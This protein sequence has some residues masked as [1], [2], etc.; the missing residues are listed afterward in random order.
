M[1]HVGENWHIPHLLISPYYNHTLALPLIHN[2]YKE[3]YHRK[4]ILYMLSKSQMHKLNLGQPIVD[5]FSSSTNWSKEQVQDLGFVHLDGIYSI[6]LRNWRKNQMYLPIWIQPTI[7]CIQI[8]IKIKQKYYFLSIIL[9]GT[10]RI[11]DI[12]I[13]LC[14]I[15]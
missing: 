5:Q 9:F 11:I 14:K 7:G 4:Y 8:S 3:I 15:R 2:P 6:Y 13:E 10:I 12:F 1:C